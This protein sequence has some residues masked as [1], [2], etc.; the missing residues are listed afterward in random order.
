MLLLRNI[1]ME[2]IIGD[3]TPFKWVVFDSLEVGDIIDNMEIT[4]K[5]DS[6]DP[7][8]FTDIMLNGGSYIRLWHSEE[9]IELIEG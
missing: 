8:V 4:G 5:R 9:I 7:G 2:N 6:L 1:E 3:V